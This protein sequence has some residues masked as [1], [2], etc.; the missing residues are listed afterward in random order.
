MF[1]FL[2]APVLTMFVL[3]GLYLFFRRT[4]RPAADLSKEENRGRLQFVLTCYVMLSA[5]LL[6]QAFLVSGLTLF[7]TLTLLLL[8]VL[9]FRRNVS[10]R[11]YACGLLI[12]LGGFYSWPV[13]SE[14]FPRPAP[15]TQPHRIDTRPSIADRLRYEENAERVADYS[16][17]GVPQTVPPTDDPPPSLDAIEHPL[18]APLAPSGY[19][20]IKID[21]DRIDFNAAYFSHYLTSRVSPSE[22]PQLS[23][24]HQLW[25]RR[26]TQT[27]GFGVG[28]MPP[29]EPRIED[30]RSGYPDGRGPLPDQYTPADQFVW[31]VEDAGRMQIN[32]DAVYDPR[33]NDV[34]MHLRS[35]TDFLNPWF[36]GSVGSRELPA[37]T[38]G[39]GFNQLP[40]VTDRE[41]KKL[42]EW[43][44][45][46]LLLVSLLKQESPR[47]YLHDRLPNMRNLRSDT[48]PTRELDRFERKSLHYLQDGYDV[49][50]DEQEDLIHMFGSL[51]ATDQC[52]QC[53]SVP[54]KSLLGAFTYEL[55]KSPVSVS[56]K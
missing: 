43:R 17:S 24:V 23:R 12:L 13:W 54:R 48:V 32:Y 35:K 33:R 10:S 8:T 36:W 38:A 49:V 40:V 11:A 52:L 51:R 37:T 7:F 42:D 45:T 46:Q 29:L 5:G 19:L 25:T 9:A 31:A 22:R 4:V 14:F 53:H 16:P 50:I 2:Y 21:Y 56:Q 47:V 30:P 28:R 41:T 44:V 3:G 6:V 39:H 18:R 20:L 26:F 34:D 27:M 1:S 15:A 55:R